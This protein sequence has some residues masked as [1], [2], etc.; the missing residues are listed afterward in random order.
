MTIDRNLIRSYF[1][2]LKIATHIDDDGDM[3]VIQSADEDFGHDVVIFVFVNNNRLSYAAGAREYRPE[4]DLL[5]LANRHNCRRNMPTAVV[6]DGNIRMECS[7]LLDEEVS[8]EYI[9]ENCIKMVL[10]T[11]WRGFCDLEKEEA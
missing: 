3:V 5:M 7:F 8:K 10:G 1:D 11:I 4:G 6:R 2:E 9:V